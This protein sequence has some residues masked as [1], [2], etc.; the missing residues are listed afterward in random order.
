LLGNVSPFIVVPG[1]YSGKELRYQAEDAATSFLMNA[2]FLCCAAKMLVLPKGWAGSDVFIQALQGVCAKVAPRQAYY[3][4]A[5]DRWLKLTTGRAQIKHLGNAMP[6]SLP[7]TFISGLDPNARDEP[8]YAQEPFC[9]VISE[10]RVGSADPVEYLERAVDFCNNRLWGTLNANLIVH[11]Q[12]LKD[13]RI[14]RDA[15]IRRGLSPIRR[16]FGKH[17]A[18]PTL[19]TGLFVV[20]HP[21]AVHAADPRCIESSDCPH[22]GEPTCRE[23]RSEESLHGFDM[24]VLVHQLTG[25]FWIV[26]GR[27]SKKTVTYHHRRVAEKAWHLHRFPNGLPAK[28][29]DLLCF[30]FRTRLKARDTESAGLAALTTLNGNRGAPPKRTDGGRLHQYLQT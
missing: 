11:P 24:S 6:G 28:L 29:F 12:S 20:R 3:P 16:W 18:A 27:H 5:E 10:T 13:P 8:L 7:W 25:A 22:T 2:S 4:G 21:S 15:E 1:P 26:P 30:L 14:A 19:P 9:S 17:L 23:V